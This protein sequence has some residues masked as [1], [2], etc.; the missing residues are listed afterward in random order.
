[1]FIR[2]LNLTIQA[3]E[4]RGYLPVWTEILGLSRIVSSSQSGQFYQ[5]V[6][7]KKRH[8]YQET[9]KYGFKCIIHFIYLISL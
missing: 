3:H 5:V 9:I 2:E 1:M 7:W 6:C 8:A 4:M